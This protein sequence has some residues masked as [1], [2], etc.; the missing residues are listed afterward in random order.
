GIKNFIGL[1]TVP[2]YYAALI[3]AVFIVVY[4]TTFIS[5]QYLK[6]RL[7]FIC[8]LHFALF[9]H[10][11]HVLFF[12]NDITSIKST[13]RVAALIYLSISLFFLFRA[14]VFILHDG[15]LSFNMMSAKE[16][17]EKD[18][19]VLTL[20]FIN[21]YFVGSYTIFLLMLNLRLEDSL[22][23]SEDIL[24][25][26]ISKLEKSD[27]AKAKF[28]SIISHDLRNPVDGMASLLSAMGGERD[29]PP[30][31]AADLKLLKKTSHGVAALLEN[32]LEWAKAQTRNIEC[33][34]SRVTVS[35]IVLEVMKILELR[36]RQKNIFIKNH[37]VSDIGFRADRRMFSTIL[38]NLVN[39]AIKFT[40]AGGEIII[41]AA[42]EKDTAA[43]IVKDNGVG[44]KS[45]VVDGIFNFDRYNHISKGTAGETGTGLGLLICREFA[46][47][48]GGAM[49]I[50]SSPGNGTEVKLTMPLWQD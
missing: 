50:T 17:I 43:V 29:I 35:E 21:L 19:Y 20:I 37:I 12:Y 7:A 23:E 1:R 48:N 3:A 47:L 8:A 31:I 5:P 30:E 44:M 6:I 25:K 46:E 15:P 26:N 10:L 4:H 14:V 16:G 42:V 11:F 27:A 38:R 9:Y 36:A 49:R 40:N 32:L 33:N 13:G 28:I 22:R 45:E 24:R 41:A 18:L 39:N 2:G 34:P